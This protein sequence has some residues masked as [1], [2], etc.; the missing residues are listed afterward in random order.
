MHQYSLISIQRKNQSLKSECQK[1]LNKLLIVSLFF[2]TPGCSNILAN[3]QPYTS[4]SPILNSNKK[5]FVQE[6]LYFGLSKPSGVVSETEWQQ[7]L[8][9]V[10]T[11]RF[12]E[13]LTVKDAYG[14][15]MNK[16]GKLSQEKTKLVILIYEKSL[17]KN[18]MVSEAIANYKRTFQQESVLRVTSNVNVSF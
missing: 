2:I 18:Q 16:S 8:N 5:I 17:A 10:I 11:P 15:Y 3:T 9:G 1:S 13:G 14:Q 7:F 4:Q 12:R 6:E